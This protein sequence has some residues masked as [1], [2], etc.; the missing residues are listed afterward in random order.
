MLIG[1]HTYPT[2]TYVHTYISHT[3]ISHTY[4]HTYPVRMPL[5]NINMT[6]TK[7]HGMFLFFASLLNLPTVKLNLP[8]Y[9]CIYLLYS[10]ILPTVKSTYLFIYLFIVLLSSSIFTYC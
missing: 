1:I 9:L 3:Y 10:S 6:T 4:I 2:H 7:T 8:I 5:L